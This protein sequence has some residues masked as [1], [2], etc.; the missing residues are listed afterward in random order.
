[1]WKNRRARKK[2]V[3]TSLEG[4]KES[5]KIGFGHT[6]S[7]E[8]GARDRRKEIDQSMP[9]RKSHDDNETGYFSTGNAEDRDS[10]S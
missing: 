4:R 2:D 8:R 1:M 3:C 9:Q 6:C 10:T 7:E 5:Q